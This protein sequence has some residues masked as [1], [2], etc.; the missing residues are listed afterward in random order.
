MTGVNHKYRTLQ[1]LH[2]N[3]HQMIYFNEHVFKLF[4]EIESIDIDTFL[5]LH[6]GRQTTRYDIGC[7]FSK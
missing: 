3:L 4:L 2:D 6:F 7:L 1:N 5:G